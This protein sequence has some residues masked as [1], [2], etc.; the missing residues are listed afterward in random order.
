MKRMS[1]FCL[2]AHL[3]IPFNDAATNFKSIQLMLLTSDMTS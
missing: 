3:L 2:P 1:Q